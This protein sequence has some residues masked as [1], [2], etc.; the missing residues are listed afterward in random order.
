MGFFHCSKPIP[1]GIKDLIL[2]MLEKDPDK[3]IK[4]PEIKVN[5]QDLS[6]VILIV[7]H[8]HDDIP[9]IYN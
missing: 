7:R 3:R 8:D 9:L 1:D 6:Q 2:K 4:L 5:G